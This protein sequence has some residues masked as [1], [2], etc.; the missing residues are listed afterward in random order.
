MMKLCREMIDREDAVLRRL[1]H[2]V[3]QGGFSVDVSEQE[4]LWRDSVRGLSGV[5][6][7]AA[8][9]DDAP[10][11][12]RYGY[13]YLNDPLSEFARREAARHRARGVA[14]PDFLALF[15]LYGLAYRDVARDI[16]GDAPCAPFLDFLERCF[17]I[18]QIAVAAEWA[19]QD[20]DTL[21]QD[22]QRENRRLANKK[23]RY[24]TL[25][26]SLSNPKIIIDDASRIREVNATARSMI[27]WL[28]S[29]RAAHE[30]GTIRGFDIRN[31][32]KVMARP[33][34]ADVFPWLGRETAEFLN[35]TDR[36]FSCEKEV[37][38]RRTPIVFDVA[39][40]SLRDFPGKFSGAV[41]TFRDVT[42]RS[43]AERELQARTQTL[44]SSVAQ[45]T[46]ELNNAVIWLLQEIGRRE[47][48]ERRIHA[49]LEEKN[50][51]LREIHH[52]VKN[53]L[54]IISSL[55]ELRAMRAQD[56]RVVKALTEARGKV[57]AIALIHSLLHRSGRLSDIDM[58]RIVE[59]MAPY[60][61]DIYGISRNAVALNVFADR[62]SLGM[63]QAVPCALVINE[64][65]SNA[66]KHAFRDSGGHFHP[67]PDA[68]ITI[69]LRQYGDSVYIEVCDNGGGIPEA[70]LL[71][72]SATLGLK[73]VRT[74]V[75]TQLKG[76]VAFMRGDGARV[77][78]TFQK[79]K[80]LTLTLDSE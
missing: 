34:L 55:L 50:V 65:M 76:Q 64:L 36:F 72:N 33:F 5:I 29:D 28:G 59:E 52:R 20:K 3:A 66:F 1:V 9:S 30:P 71:E 13:D 12:L 63:A 14:L 73:M 43:L 23:N 25:F 17:D 7:A 8:E 16:C 26:H 67:P 53:N 37:P 62:L 79:K 41:I 11:T 15:K 78:V 22:L 45:R 10:A 56:D 4:R 61:F 31:S 75:Q 77:I 35:G 6:A 32:G 46:T 38:L 49:A 21:L 68:H 54:Q 39:F 42:R 18:M 80:P 27:K 74:L 19:G 58:E 44:E 47:E 24:R 69:H 51:L 48:T 2:L 70:D 60:L 57:H 40:A